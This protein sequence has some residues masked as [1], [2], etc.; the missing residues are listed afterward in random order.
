MGQRRFVIGLG[1]AALFAGAVGVA[2][3][4]AFAQELAP[5]VS[6]EEYTCRN[7]TD[8]T[9]RVEST[10]ACDGPGVMTDL[11]RAITYVPPRATVKVSTN[12]FPQR[13]PGSWER[14]PGKL[15]PDGTRDRGRRVWK[16]GDLI[17]THPVGITHRSAEVDN[18]PPPPATGSFGR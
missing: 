1:I 16:Q 17:P 5:G 11:Q 3:P 9:Y 13:G 7:D 14:E 15:Q 6:C 8:D 4:Q 10:V 18:N 2:A 12:C